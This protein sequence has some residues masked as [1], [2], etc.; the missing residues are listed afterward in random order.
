MD[1]LDSAVDLLNHSTRSMVVRQSQTY[2]TAPVGLKEQPDFLNR[3][4]ELNSELMPREL[5]GL[6]LSVE[7]SMGRK[8]E[9]RNGP[10]TIDLDLLLYHDWLLSTDSLTLPHPRMEQRRF[11]LVPLLELEPE[12]QSPGSGRYLREILDEIEDTE[13]GITPYHG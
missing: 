13:Q 4:A 10:R 8:R 9:V 11:V 7:Q 1:N 3:V 2:E 6:L 12:L 5:L